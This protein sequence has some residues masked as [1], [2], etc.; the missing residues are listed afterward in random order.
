M[1]AVLKCTPNT[2]FKLHLTRPLRLDVIF[3]FVVGWILWGG[4]RP[5]PYKKNILGGAGCELLVLEAVCGGSPDSGSQHVLPSPSSSVPPPQ[6][7]V[8][9]RRAICI[10]EV[11]ICHVKMVA[12]RRVAA[13]GP[14]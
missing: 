13:Q 10:P 8:H 6:P 1:G 5:G 7:H 11:T 2:A 14:R 12:G 4:Q 9:A 3:D